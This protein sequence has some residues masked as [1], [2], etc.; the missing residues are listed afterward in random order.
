MAVKFRGMKPKLKK[1]TFIWL[2]VV[3]LGWGISGWFLFT[4]TK[5]QS[6]WSVAIAFFLYL[7][8]G[9]VAYRAGTA[10][11]SNG[12]CRVRTHWILSM[13]SLTGSVLGYLISLKLT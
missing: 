7:V 6:F 9:Q 13:V 3:F 12:L 10:I 5:L 11:K 2:V 4:W 1:L 8:M